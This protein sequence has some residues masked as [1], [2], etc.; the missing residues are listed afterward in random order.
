MKTV[1][2]EMKTGASTNHVISHFMS[3]YDDLRSP[4]VVYH[5]TV[6]SAGSIISEGLLCICWKNRC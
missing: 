6:W 4:S 1:T 3:E 2:Y 5:P